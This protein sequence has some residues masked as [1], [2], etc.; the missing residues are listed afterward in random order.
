MP[1]VDSTVRVFGVTY[2]WTSCIFAINGIQL[3]GITSVSRSHKRE[4]PLVYAARRDGK[5][6]ARVG[7]GKYTPA[8]LKVKWLKDTFEFVKTTIL[9]PLGA[10]SYGDASFIFTLQCIEPVI[11][12]IPTTAIAE[13][14]VIDDDDDNREEST[15]GGLMVETTISSLDFNENVPLWSIARAIG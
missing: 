15:P 14:C 12:T 5:P 6:V 3:E 7:G 11:G 4:R 13:D 2:S 1:Q 10:G 9:A 8:T